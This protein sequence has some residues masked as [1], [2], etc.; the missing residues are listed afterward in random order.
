MRGVPSPK[1]SRI[2]DNSGHPG[3][4]WE[5]LPD[6]TTKDPGPNISRSSRTTWDIPE[7]SGMSYKIFLHF[8][9]TSRLV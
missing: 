5:V 2:L 9:F 8:I 3:I 4:S 6:M 1:I 7:Y